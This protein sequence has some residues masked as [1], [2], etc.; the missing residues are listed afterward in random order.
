MLGLQPLYESVTRSIYSVVNS[1][2]LSRKS[3][4]DFHDTINTYITF[5]FIIH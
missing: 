5:R 3:K 1:I 2:N 4:K